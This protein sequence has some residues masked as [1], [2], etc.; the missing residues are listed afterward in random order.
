MNI[1]SLVALS[2]M[3]AVGALFLMLFFALKICV[4]RFG[5]LI[6]RPYWLLFCVSLG[7]MVPPFARDLAL[8]HGQ[9]MSLFDILMACAWICGAIGLAVSLCW[10]AIAGVFSFS[11]WIK[12][13]H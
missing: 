1:L 13:K 3:F 8:D 5:I 9:A 4:Q 10:M 12:H 6:K 2:V 7:F 11:S